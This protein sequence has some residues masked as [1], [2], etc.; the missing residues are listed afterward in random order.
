MVIKCRKECKFR[1]IMITSVWWGWLDGRAIHWPSWGW[2]ACGLWGIPSPGWRS[3]W[4][5]CRRC[6]QNELV[7]PGWRASRRH[8]GHSACAAPVPSG[9]QGWG[10][11][12]WRPPSPFPGSHALTSWWRIS[13]GVVTSGLGLTPHPQSHSPPFQSVNPKIDTIFLPQIVTKYFM[14]WY[15]CH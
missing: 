14:G 9:P 7:S 13:V 10:R 8:P 1:N 11:A 12:A 15:L 5:W 3:W 2:S 6:S 4:R